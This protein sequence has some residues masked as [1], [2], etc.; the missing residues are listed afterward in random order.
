MENDQFYM[1]D[2]IDWANR[3]NRTKRKKNRRNKWK[4]LAINYYKVLTQKLKIDIGLYASHAPL[5]LI[6]CSIIFIFPLEWKRWIRKFGYDLEFCLQQT[7]IW[8]EINQKEKIEINRTFR[9]KKKIWLMKCS[10]FFYGIFWHKMP[11][12]L[13]LT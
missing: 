4:S 3:M 7:K 5:Q 11:K 10:S 13:V 12:K 8:Y 2:S 6:C 9:C 1:I